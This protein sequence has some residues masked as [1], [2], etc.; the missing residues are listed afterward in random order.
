[1]AS[2]NLIRVGGHGAVDVVNS[3]RWSVSKS[4]LAT[5]Q[6]PIIKISEYQ[7]GLAGI[8]QSIRHWSR[9]GGDEGADAITGDVQDPYAELY[10]VDMR[11][12]QRGNDYV[13]PFFSD[14]HHAI[15][16]AWGENKGVM[17][18]PASELLKHATDLARAIYPSAGIESAQSFEGSTRSEYLFTFHLFNTVDPKVDIKKNLQ[19]IQALVNNN[20]LDK[21]NLMAI[22]PPAICHISIPGIRGATVG[23][24][25]NIVIQNIGQMN[26]INLATLGI[27][28]ADALSIGGILGKQNYNI[29]DA[30][31]ITITVK[32]L[33]T[34][35]RQIW[36]GALNET[37]KVF[38]GVASDIA[39]TVANAGDT[40]KKPVEAIRRATGI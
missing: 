6:V 30:Y 34:E 40:I 36:D 27:E 12:D 10:A 29:P 33:L 19:L 38:G 39:S 32:E 11:E 14:Y 3:Y 8:Q 16:N 24:M 21:I 1:M 2:K 31:Q 5:A 13:F 4:S 20:V 35:S 7:Q 28:G 23:I 15:S 22:R 9:I 17:A 37:D 18:Q 26:S 25:S